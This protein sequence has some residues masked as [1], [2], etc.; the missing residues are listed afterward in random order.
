MKVA[1]RMMAI[2]VDMVVAVMEN[3]VVDIIVGFCMIWVSFLDV[4]EV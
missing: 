3:M 1:I 2:R 4:G